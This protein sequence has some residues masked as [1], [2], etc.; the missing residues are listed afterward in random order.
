MDFIFAKSRTPWIFRDRE[1]TKVGA[2]FERDL[3]H[4]EALTAFGEK[5]FGIADDIE[6]IEDLS[7]MCQ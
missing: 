4:G 3:P 5:A 6:A 1:A 7:P 2:I